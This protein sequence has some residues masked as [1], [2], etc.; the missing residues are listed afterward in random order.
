[1]CTIVQCPSLLILNPFFGVWCCAIDEELYT[2]FHIH[3]IFW[4]YLYV[5]GFF[6]FIS[7]DFFETFP[8]CSLPSTVSKKK[9]IAHHSHLTEVMDQSHT[10]YACTCANQ[11]RYSSI[12]ATFC[13]TNSKQFIKATLGKKLDR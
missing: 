6:I 4:S 11:E 2:I 13:G 3:C 7:D 9:M 1:M 10:L 12:H 8:G 5:K